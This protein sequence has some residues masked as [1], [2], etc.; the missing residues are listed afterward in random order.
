MIVTSFV[1]SVALDALE[2]VRYQ[3]PREGSVLG[4]FEVSWKNFLHEAGLVV[5]HEG[6]A[7]RS[8]SND[9]IKVIFL[10][11]LQHSVQSFGKSNFAPAA[12]A[13]A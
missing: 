7:V 12:V 9:I 1:R 4:L 10:R 13:S 8:P 5:H 6:P 11:I 2:A 3:L